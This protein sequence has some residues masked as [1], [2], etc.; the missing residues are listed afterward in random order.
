MDN[1]FGKV[2]R[3]E[4][5]RAS[6][7]E[8]E[9]AGAL[10]YDVTYISKWINGSK[11]PSARNAEQIINRIAAFFA[12][13]CGKEQAEKKK[14]SRKIYEKLRQAYDS[15]SS[16]QSLQNYDNHQMSFIDNQQMLERLIN[17]ACSQVM[18]RR[19]GNICIAATFDIFQL[20]GREFKNLMNNLKDEEGNGKIEIRAA[21]DLENLEKNYYSYAAD[22][23]NIIGQS[24]YIE[25]SLV[26]QKPN[27]PKMLIIDDFLCLQILWDTRREMAAVFSM[28]RGIVDRFSNMV[29]Q[30]IETSEKLI[31]SASPENLKKTNVQL[32]SYSDHRQW[33]FFNEP[34]AMLFPEELMDFLIETTEDE[35]YASYLIKLKNIFATRTC[36]SRIDLV[37]YS[38]MINRYLSEG[39]ISVGNVS[40][41]FSQEQT[42][43]HLQ[44]LCSVMESNPNFIIYLIRDTVVLD[45][46]LRQA[47][48]IFIDSSSLYI[49]NSKKEP[50]ANYHVSMNPKMRKAFERFFEKML[51]Q[52]YCTRL[53]A[54]DLLRYL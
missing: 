30:V 14:C 47:P 33:L 12:D 11:L 40:H 50:N 28:E 29:S 52:S 9:L 27:Q 23:L 16:Y 39:L 32:D 2:L 48:S 54:E 8:S 41:R 34:P 46:E 53:T 10:S 15:D 20:Y 6:I 19:D 26:A 24:N 45:E 51:S 21:I 25:I 44:Y 4:M 35:D 1:L 3:E 37:L 36:K 49:E 22:I 38:S 17:E 43:K 31:D 13:Y 42:R 18:K 5:K 7:K